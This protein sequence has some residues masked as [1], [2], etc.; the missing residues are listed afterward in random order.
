M[1]SQGL[2]GV[3]LRVFGSFVLLVS[4]KPS[5]RKARRELLQ[6]VTCSGLWWF[7][8]LA[9]CN[10]CPRGVTLQRACGAYNA[11]FTRLTT[12]VKNVSRGLRLLSVRRLRIAAEACLGHLTEF[13]VSHLSPGG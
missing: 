4:N 11:A 13:S 8:Q 12:L 3:R 10:M 5:A 9:G 2:P 1:P 7:P 6:P